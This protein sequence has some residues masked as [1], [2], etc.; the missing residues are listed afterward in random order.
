MTKT[1]KIE[2]LTELR[3][4]ELIE[5]L[6]RPQF[7]DLARDLERH[8]KNIDERLKDLERRSAI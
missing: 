3:A 2:Y 7:R 5:E 1:K 6:M 8:L 4:R